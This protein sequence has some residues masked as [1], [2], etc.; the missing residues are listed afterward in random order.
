MA[1]SRK[2]ISEIAKVQLLESAVLNNDIPAVQNLFSEY[3]KI[4]F[5]ARA[6]G[7][8]CRYST[9]EMVKLLVQNNVTFSYD[10]SPVI[11]GKYGVLKETST[12]FYYA[13]YRILI[14]IPTIGSITNSVTRSIER[15]TL[16]F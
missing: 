4:E 2:K 7:F 16:F 8:A 9:L 15:I 5:T 1:G 10:Y 14:T 11:Q 13:D 3:G 6:L 12:R